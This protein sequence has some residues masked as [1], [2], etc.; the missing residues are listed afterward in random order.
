MPT[1]HT[2]RLVMALA[3]SQNVLTV[4]RLVGSLPRHGTCG[5]EGP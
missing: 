3:K 2:C 1:D 4:S 5:F